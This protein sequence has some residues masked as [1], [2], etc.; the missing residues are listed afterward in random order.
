MVVVVVAFVVE[1][2]LSS[3]SA[4]AV[5]MERSSC[6]TSASVC[7]STF[8]SMEDM[9]RRSVSFSFLSASLDFCEGAAA[10]VVAVDVAAVVVVSETDWHMTVG[11]DDSVS[12]SRLCTLVPATL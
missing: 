11:D 8:L 1:V 10:E 5:A 12:R 6:F 2:A 7:L 9:M 3:D 4:V